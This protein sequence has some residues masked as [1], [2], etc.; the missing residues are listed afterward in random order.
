MHRVRRHLRSGLGRRRRLRGRG[1]MDFLKKGAQFVKDNQLISKGA[2]LLAPHV[3]NR[4]GS[5]AGNILNKV[6]TVAGAL[7]YGRMNRRRINRRGY[8][9]R[10]AGM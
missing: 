9:L 8:G 1:L 10:L 6:G 7:G 5:N 3:T 2:S 4:F